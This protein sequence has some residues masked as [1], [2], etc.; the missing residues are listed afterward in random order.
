MVERKRILTP[1]RDREPAPKLGR[2]TRAEAQ[3]R[4]IDEILERHADG[5]ALVTICGQLHLRPATFRA[6]CR[7][8]PAL[9]AEWRAV[10]L[11]YVDALFDQLAAITGE[12]ADASR[13]SG[14]D[15]AANARVNS[16]KAA[17]DGLKHVTARLRPALY[18]DSKGSGSAMTVI[19]NTDLPIGPGQEAGA[20]VDGDFTIVVP[21][22]E[23]TRGR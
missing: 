21:V 10:R 8:D 20:T 11:D 2:P 1:P 6:W 13:L 14:E 4:Q 16:L 19:F 17:Q 12:L 23:L 22:K 7:A 3:Q 18:G 5:E 9:D 15:K